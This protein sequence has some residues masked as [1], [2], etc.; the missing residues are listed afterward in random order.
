[1]KTIKPNMKMPELLVFIRFF[2]VGFVG[3]EVFSAT[4]YLSTRYAQELYE[5]SPWINT[6]VFFTGIALC[7]TYAVNR[8]AVITGERMI[9][10][11]RL[12]LLL[13]MGA[14]VW[15]NTLAFP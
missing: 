2:V 3:A 10:S 7:L 4:F 13:I 14:G 5:L 9:R 15:S 12:D 1:M 8:G 6:V 11:F